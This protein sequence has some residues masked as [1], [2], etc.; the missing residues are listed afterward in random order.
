MQ[1][2]EWRL[3]ID[4]HITNRREIISSFDSKFSPLCKSVDVNLFYCLL[5]LHPHPR[6]AYS[7]GLYTPHYFSIRARGMLGITSKA[8]R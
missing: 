6:Y 3:K 1:L 5:N 2:F 8:L 4:L 7:T